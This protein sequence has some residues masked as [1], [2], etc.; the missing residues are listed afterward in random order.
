MDE[1]GVRRLEV[2][3]RHALRADRQRAG[4]DRVQRV[5]ALGSAARR[6]GRHLDRL[7]GGQGARRS[8]ERVKE[9]DARVGRCRVI[10]LQPNSYA[11]ALYNS[12]LDDN[13][14]RNP[15][16]EGWVIRSLH[17]ADRQPGL[18]HDPARG[19]RRPEHRDP[20]RAAGRRAARRGLRAHVALGVARRR[21]AALLPHQ[22]L[23][24]RPGPGEVDLRA[25]PGDEGRR[26]SDGCPL[27]RS[28]AEEE[29]QERRAARTAHYGYDPSRVYSEM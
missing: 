7:A 15:D 1:P 6:Q 25:Q 21:Q 18:L 23:R 16:G 24:V 19:H 12:H 26:R 22:L 20:H 10:E 3:G 13:N 14:R 2:L 5:L 29:A 9:V 27:R 11:D 28:E 17:A 8:C 4:R